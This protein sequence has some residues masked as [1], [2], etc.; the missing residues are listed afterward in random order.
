MSK[1]I[2]QWIS[3]NIKHIHIT[4]VNLE[5][6]PVDFD[7]LTLFIGVL[8]PVRDK[9]LEHF[10][11]K[12]RDLSHDIYVYVFQRH[13]LSLPVDFM[14]FHITYLLYLQSYST[15]RTWKIF[16]PM[17]NNIRGFI[18]KFVIK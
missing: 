1:L 9:E 18:L 15:R 2:S 7:F 16:Q 11:S 6:V 4:W 5:K 14:C 10:V 13:F 17:K 8:I 3:I 12:N